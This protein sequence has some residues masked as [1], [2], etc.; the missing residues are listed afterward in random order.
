MGL[1]RSRGAERAGRE[2]KDAPHAKRWDTA[3]TSPTRGE[4]SSDNKTKLRIG[5]AVACSSSGSAENER[6][7]P[8][9]A[10]R[11]R[12]EGSLEGAAMVKAASNVWERGGGLGMLWL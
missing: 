7:T 4:I 5:L 9:P 12:A 8:C 6:S 1:T 10:E 2:V 11:C 3:R